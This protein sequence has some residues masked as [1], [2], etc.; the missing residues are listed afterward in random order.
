MWRFATAFFIVN[1]EYIEHDK[2]M[3]L[4]LRDQLEILV[5]I[6]ASVHT[7]CRPAQVKIIDLVHNR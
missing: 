7:K 1:F 3:L 2:L 5:L 4:L 6:L